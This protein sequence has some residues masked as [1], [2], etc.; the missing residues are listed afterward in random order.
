[1]GEIE[2]VRVEEVKGLFEEEVEERDVRG[3]GG[4]FYWE[5]WGGRGRGGGMLGR[6]C[7]Y[8]SGVWWVEVSER[9]EVEGWGE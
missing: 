5:K 8:K 2:G 7:G 9:V 3:R 1:M 4:V 6:G